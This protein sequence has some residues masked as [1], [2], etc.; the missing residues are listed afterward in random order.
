M[1]LLVVVVIPVSVQSVSRPLSLSLLLW[2]G[3][4]PLFYNIYIYIFLFAHFPFVFS[5]E[6]APDSFYVLYYDDDYYYY[7]KKK[8]REEPTVFLLKFYLLNFN[9][10]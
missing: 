4:F 3:V 8:R 7:L 1:F 5:P 9:S 10:D 6:I 2:C